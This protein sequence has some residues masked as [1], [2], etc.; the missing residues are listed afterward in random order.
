LNLRTHHSIRARA[1]MLKQTRECIHRHSTQAAHQI[2]PYISLCRC[3]MLRRVASE[4]VQN[5]FVPTVLLVCPPPFQPRP[6]DEILW[7]ADVHLYEDELHDNGE[8][9]LLVR[10]RVTPNYFYILQRLFVRVDQVTFR[11]KETRL[12]HRFGT[13][14]ALRQFTERDQSYDAVASQCSPKEIAEQILHDPNRLVEKLEVR[15]D[16]TEKFEL[17][18][19]EALPPTQGDIMAKTCMA[20]EKFKKKYGNIKPSAGAL[21]QRQ[22]KHETRYFDSGD[23]FSNKKDGPVAGADKE[24]QPEPLNV[25]STAAVVEGEVVVPVIQPSVSEIESQSAVAEEK[26]KK[27]YGNIKPSAGALLQRQKKHETRYFDS[28]DAFGGAK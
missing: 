22:K 2:A 16:E 23:A 25:L 8:C 18:R 7:S 3:A 12:H 20:E 15:F 27:K 17:G 10:T 13:N 19:T 9:S 11:M 6:G 1:H 24:P 5:A 4:N 21:L 14:F 26:F 28:G